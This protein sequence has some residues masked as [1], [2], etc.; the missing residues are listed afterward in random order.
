MMAPV[1]SICRTHQIKERAMS[2]VNLDPFAEI[3]SVFGPMLSRASGLFPRLSR[4]G[5]VSVEWA[6]TS[7]I[8]ETD[9]EY[10]IRVGLPGV[11]KEDIKVSVTNRF[12]TVE[13]ERKQEKEEKNEKFHRVESFYGS[14]SRRFSLPDNIQAE[15]VSSDYKDGVLSVRIPKNEVPKSTQIAVK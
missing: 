9:K 2:L 5:E 15:S 13:G 1:R 7:D 11:K 4:D 10:L 6:P 8:S 12:I 3:Q 14:F